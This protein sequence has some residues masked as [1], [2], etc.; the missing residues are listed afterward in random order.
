MRSRPPG[1]A[2][3]RQVSQAYGFNDIVYT[4]FQ[5]KQIIG[6]GAGQTIAI[7]SAFRDPTIANDLRAF[8]AQF[9]LPNRAAQG[10]FALSIAM[11]QGVPKVNADWAQET[12]LDVEWAH[13]MAPAA[14]ILLI[15]TKTDSPVDLFKGVDFARK[16]QGVTVVSM[17]WGWDT[18]PAGVDYQ[19]ILTTPAKHVGGLSNGDGVTFIEAGSD[20]GVPTAFPDASVPVISVGGTTLTLDASGNYAGE[21]P[22]AA[23]N[24]S[25]TVAYDADPNTGFAVYDSTDDRGVQGWQVAGGTSAGAPQWAAVFAIADQLRAVQ[26]KHSL[27]GPTAALPALTSLP[28][29]DFHAIPGGGANMGRGTPI[30]NRVAIADL[31]GQ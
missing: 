5:G 23:S 4:N 12:A 21:T 14:H 15:E 2:S 17:S 28:A 3:P 31:V 19:N 20:D 25:A 16:H 30:A 18:S 29:S 8:D 10:G 13:A 26:G 6:N 24:A 11:P 22:L 27:D 1:F 7:V 9:G